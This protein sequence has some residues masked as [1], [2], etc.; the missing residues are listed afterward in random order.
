MCQVDASALINQKSCIAAHT[1][2]PIVRK[3]FICFRNTESTRQAQ[4]AVYPT[5]S[6]FLESDRSAA[7]VWIQSLL[8]GTPVHVQC[9]CSVWGCVLKAGF[10]FCAGGVRGPYCAAQ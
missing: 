2:V 9:E 10:G 4:L 7:A 8:G 6:R 3:H 1:E 5:A